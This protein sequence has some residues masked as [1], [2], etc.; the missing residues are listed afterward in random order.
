MLF[1]LAWFSHLDSSTICL[2]VHPTS[3]EGKKPTEQQQNNQPTKP[4]TQTNIK[5]QPQ[6]K[7]PHSLQKPPHSYGRIMLV[8]WL[9]S[10]SS[11]N[12]VLRLKKGVLIWQEK[13][14][15]G[16]EI[17]ILYFFPKGAGIFGK[18][19]SCIKNKTKQNK[20]HLAPVLFRSIWPEEQSVVLTQCEERRGGNTCQGHLLS[21]SNGTL[22]SSHKT[23]LWYKIPLT[24]SF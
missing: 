24:A 1:L 9:T 3:Q 14:C 19:W 21:G 15:L 2:V 17:C 8:R 16:L 4:P 10:S 12:E 11:L 23:S 7:K 18:L 5:N 13:V 6:N 20:P 22:H